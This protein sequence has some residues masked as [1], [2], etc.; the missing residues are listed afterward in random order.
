[1]SSRYRTK[2][3]CRFRRF[4]HI[5]SIDDTRII[6]M[7]HKINLIR[8]DDP[9]NIVA[10]HYIRTIRNYVI[11]KFAGLHH[12][13]TLLII[14]QRSTLALRDRR[15]RIYTND[16]VCTQGAPQTKRVYVPIMETVKGAVHEDSYIVKTT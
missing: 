13:K 9:I 11:H 7:D 4:V 6:T 1:M 12:S 8:L 3:T 2:F 10:I 5:F 14:H 16:K 15:I